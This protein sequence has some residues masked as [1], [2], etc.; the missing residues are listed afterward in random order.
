MGYRS[1]VA[2]KCKEDA[3]KILKDVCNKVNFTP[4]TIF[5]DDDQYILY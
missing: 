4:D 3:Y 5:K 2:I 1:E